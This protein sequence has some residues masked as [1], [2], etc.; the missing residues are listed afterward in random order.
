MGRGR[1]PGGGGWSRGW[2]GA[3]GG[4]QQRPGRRNEP[5]A[6]RCRPGQQARAGHAAACRPPGQP[7]TSTQH[8]APSRAAL[9]RH[10]RGLGALLH[11][12]VRV[13]G[14][15]RRLGLAP[16]QVLPVARQLRLVVQLQLQAA[17]RQRVPQRQAD[18][19]QHLRAHRLVLQRLLEGWVGGWVGWVDVRAAL[20]PACLHAPC[21]QQSCATQRNRWPATRQLRR[22]WKALMQKARYVTRSCMRMRPAAS[23]PFSPSTAWKKAGKKSCAGG[24]G[25]GMVRVAGCDV[26]GGKEDSNRVRASSRRRW[27]AAAGRCW[28]AAAGG[29]RRRPRRPS[30]SRRP[31]SRRQPQAHK[32]GAAPCCAAG[33]RPSRAPAPGT[34]G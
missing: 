9:T 6:R 18:Q 26:R 24:G 3:V 25:V 14:G 32:S 11:R 19:A 15:G 7:S 30:P 8:P 5:A 34:F 17:A 20:R 1:C 27:S 29:C 10:K 33:S 4:V 21:G 22:T 12:H 16:G 31:P 23:P 2:S 13:A 28:P